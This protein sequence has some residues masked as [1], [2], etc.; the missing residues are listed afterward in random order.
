M[1]RNKIIGF[2]LAFVLFVVL[3]KPAF[4]DAT[5]DKPMVQLLAF[6]GL[7]VGMIVSGFLT[8][9]KEKEEGGH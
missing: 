8:N 3:F 2:V 6:L 7:L 1:N 5:H 4:I 9:G